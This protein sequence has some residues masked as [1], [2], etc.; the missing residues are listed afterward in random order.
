MYKPSN[1]PPPA[2]VPTVLFKEKTTYSYWLR[3][4]R[5]MSKPERFGIGE[6]IDILFLQILELTHTSRFT[7]I[8]N[9]LPYLEQAVL[10]I[11][12]IKFFAE[13]AWENKL[14]NNKEYSEFFHKL[15]EIG[16][17]LG[18]WKKGLSK[19]SHS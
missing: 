1:L 11:D 3:L 15:E 18:G 14:I 13:I 17:E 19:N 7:S 4:Y 16:R 8:S 10:K 2:K 12:R 6:K 5:R 9:K